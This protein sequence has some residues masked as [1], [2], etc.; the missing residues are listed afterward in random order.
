MHAYTHILHTSTTNHVS[1][2]FQA[3]GAI[4]LTNNEEEKALNMILD[5]HVLKL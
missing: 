5:W 4:S 1:S 3:P 2:P